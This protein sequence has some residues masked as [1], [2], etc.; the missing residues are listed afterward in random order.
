MYSLCGGC[1]TQELSGTC[2]FLSKNLCPLNA[3]RFCVAAKVSPDM[4]TLQMAA[5]KGEC[6]ILRYLPARS[7]FGS[8]VSPSPPSRGLRG[9]ASYVCNLNVVSREGGRA[10]P[11]FPGSCLTPASEA[12][13]S[14]TFRLNSVPDSERWANYTF[15]ERVGA[16]VHLQ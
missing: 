16:V 3:V 14:K 11:Y 2:H 13:Q 7:L 12:F 6:C 1:L 8:L 5:S 4:M 10:A 9:G 15:I